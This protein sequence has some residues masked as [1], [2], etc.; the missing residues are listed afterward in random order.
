MGTKRDRKRRRRKVEGRLDPRALKVREVRAELETT[1][2]GP[3]PPSGRDEAMIAHW[4]AQKD[5]RRLRLVAK[6]DPDDS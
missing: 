6:P 2:P 3:T 4:R 5:A 1:I